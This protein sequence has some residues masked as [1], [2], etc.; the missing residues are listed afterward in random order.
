MS[1]PF[2]FQIMHLDMSILRSSGLQIYPQ[3]PSPN[4]LQSL[5][6]LAYTCDANIPKPADHFDLE[7]S[8]WFSNAKPQSDVFFVPPPFQPFS[9]PSPHPLPS[10]SP[11]D[12]SYEDRKPFLNEYNEEMAI[13]DAIQNKNIFLPILDPP[14]MPTITEETPKMDNFID[15]I[16][17][18][19]HT[20]EDFQNLF[21]GIGELETKP[22]PKFH[23]TLFTRQESPIKI[24]ISEDFI[25]TLNFKR[26]GP[27][28]DSPPMVVPSMENTLL[29]EFGVFG[30]GDS[31]EELAGFS[32]QQFGFA[33]FESEG[34]DNSETSSD[35]LLTLQRRPRSYSHR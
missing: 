27:F 2:I 14:I 34:R 30:T 12:D 19:E 15:L 1:F 31:A 20:N 33:S 35:S 5:T 25:P 4:H 8:M 21:D 6:Q 32:D 29:P 22:L 23:K 16:H 13:H 10:V 9:A 18:N 17:I 7:S 11:I 24:E 26:E 3:E 28:C